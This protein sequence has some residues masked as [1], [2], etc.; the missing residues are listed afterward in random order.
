MKAG[1]VFAFALLTALLYSILGEAVGDFGFRF[2]LVFSFL[3]YPPLVYGYDHYCDRA[4]EQ[5]I[6]QLTQEKTQEDQPKTPTK[7][8]EIEYGKVRSRFKTQR[9]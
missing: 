9:K 7:K 5:I 6:K 8:E 2:L 3:L 4:R 1:N